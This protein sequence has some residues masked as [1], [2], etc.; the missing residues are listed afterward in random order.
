MT[1]Q[2]DSSRLTLPVLQARAKITRA[3]LGKHGAWYMNAEVLRYLNE[4]AAFARG[5]LT[6]EEFLAHFEDT[7]ERIRT[8]R[9]PISR[10]E[11]SHG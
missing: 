8:S 10:K 6:E 5:K 9:V 1:G 2:A 4:G 3:N 7:Y 11:R